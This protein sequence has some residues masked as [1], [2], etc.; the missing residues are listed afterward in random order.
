MTLSQNTEYRMVLPIGQQQFTLVYI[1]EASS[2]SAAQVSVPLILNEA[3]AVPANMTSNVKFTLCPDGL[4]IGHDDVHLEAQ[5]KEREVDHGLS[6]PLA[7]KHS[8]NDQPAGAWTLKHAGQNAQDPFFFVEAPYGEMRPRLAY[9]R[10]AP[11]T[12][13]KL[14][15]ISFETSNIKQ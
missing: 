7:V 6:A 5:M 12:S 3:N 10:E 8:D 14:A 13:S 1:K 9:Q 2:L 4:K 11:L 15:A